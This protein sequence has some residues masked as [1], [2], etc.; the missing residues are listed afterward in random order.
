MILASLKD[1]AVR[2]GLLENADYEPKPVRWRINVSDAGEFLGLLDTLGDAATGKKPQ[3]VSLMIPRRAGRTVKPVADF[4][5]DKSEYVLGIYP[6]GQRDAAALLR[7]QALFRE[8]VSLAAQ[9]TGLPSLRAVARF[10]ESSEA[11]GKCIEELQ[12][13]V[14]AS[15]DLLAF[16]YRGEWTHDAS[17]V[18]DYFA[19]IRSPVVGE[20]LQCLICGKLRT[21]VDKHPQVQISGGSSSGISLVSFNAPAF[22]SYGWIRNAN[23]PVCRPCADAYTSALTRNLKDGYLGPGGEKLGKRSIRL[24]DNTTAVY[25]ADT[26]SDVVDLFASLFSAP[27]PEAVK[28]VLTAAFQGSSPPRLGARLYCLLLSGGQGR[29]TVRGYH[30]GSLEAVERNVRD[31]FR[32]ATVED[33]PVPLMW[34]LRSLAVR[35]KDENLPA[36]LVTEIFLSI[37]FNRP[38]P[39]WVLHA[40]LLRSRAEGKVIK[41]RA[42][43]LA[44]YLSRARE[45]ERKEIGMSL[46]SNNREAA[47]LLG[48]LLA[49]LE[50]LQ[51]DA[52]GAGKSAANRYFAAASTRPV[53]VFPA[54]I[55]L[56]Q[57]HLRKLKPGL[58]FHINREIGELMG[59]IAQFPT[60]LAAAQQA[61][62]ALG[63]YHQ[64]EFRPAAKPEFTTAIE[65]QEN[66][67]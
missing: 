56:A 29:A 14:Y 27:K 52:Q 58:A 25:W 53:T 23:A 65:G 24:N 50:R 22:E 37:L 13:R 39:R 6:D 20:T 66:E 12:S 10:L 67:K 18:R 55:R 60:S 35:Q 54:M 8:Q 31:W 1:L 62:F 21:P 43:L 15:N 17:E 34:L 32:L 28:E 16:F 49:K 4:L 41:E 51:R 42:V 11:V 5:V 47:Y 57:H 30:T 61:E 26:S 7:K 46:D 19:S 63:Y 48:R 36:G 64:R 33:R 3:A 9:S 38:L 45:S 40:A 59:D 2:E 44:A